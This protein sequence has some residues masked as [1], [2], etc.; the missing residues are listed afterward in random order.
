MFKCTLL[1]CAMILTNYATASSQLV[2]T[3]K[4]IKPSIVGIGI[5]DPLASPRAQLIGSGF[6]IHD[7]QHVATNYHVVSRALSEDK[8]Q[9]YIV[10]IGE[11]KHPEIATAEIVASDPVHDLAILKIEKKLPALTL[12]SNIQ[13]SDGT[14][15]AFTGF[16]I[17]SVLGLYP[18]THKGIIAAYT[19]NIRPAVNSN[20]LSIK[21][22]RRL[23]K[24]FF[25]YQLDATAYPGNSGSA[26]YRQDTGEVI[27]I[28]NKVFIK[29]TKEN[30]LS[31]PSGISYA[32]PVD[33][34]H[35]LMKQ[36]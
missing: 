5:Y 15:I 17:G 25:V 34:L 8:V 24:P 23:K 9:D 35:N 32:I 22:L 2:Q 6:A 4:Q 28:I 31:N 29:E 10:L 3:I 13:V 30:V 33:Y 18:A 36:L 27:G 26:L 16:P 7:G 11:G 20:Q 19:P 14:D 12:A 1:L 21:M